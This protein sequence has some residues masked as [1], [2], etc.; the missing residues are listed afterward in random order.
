MASIP[1]DY[2][3]DRATGFGMTLNSHMRFGYITRLDGFG[4]TQPA[5]ADLTVTVPYNGQ[6]RYSGIA[7]KPPATAGQPRTAAVVG[8]L[9]SFNWAGGVGDPITVNFWC[10][11]QNAVAIKT[12]QQ[13]VLKTTVVKALGWWIAGYDQ[14]TK[15]WFE[16]SYPVSAPTVTGVI[17]VKGNPE[18]NVDLTP[19]PVADGIDVS[20]YKVSL[21]VQS[22]ANQQYV[23]DFANSPAQLMAK[24]WGLVTGAVPAGPV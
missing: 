15:Q 14:A 18:L 5:T 20:V 24:P 19:V 13:A 3:C 8:V 1:F 16:Q 22:A 11:Q 23:L 12:T 17:A 10:S 2:D 9:E 6:P 7:F 4:L 21:S